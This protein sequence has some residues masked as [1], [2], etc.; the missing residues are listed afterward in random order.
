MVI[1][2]LTLSVKRTYPQLCL[3]KKPPVVWCQVVEFPLTGSG[4]IQKFVIRDRFVA[5]EY[6]QSVGVGE[7]H[8]TSQIARRGI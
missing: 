3:L 7:R 2:P 6:R 8:S 1:D 4:K 5:G